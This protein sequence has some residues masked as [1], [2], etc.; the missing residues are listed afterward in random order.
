MDTIP[1]HI[2]LLFI[3]TSFLSF[4]LFYKATR[5]SKPTIIILVTWIILQTILGWSGFFQV[6]DMI[7]PRLLM[8]VLATLLL[9]IGLFSTPDGRNFIDALELKQLCLVH[10]VRIPVEIV[11]YLLFL[12]K[13]IPE[14]MTLSG[15]NYDIL[16]GITA[17]IIYY[18]G[19]QKK[20]LS[21]NIIL[22]W[23]FVCLGLLLNIVVNAVLAAPF[24]FQQFAFDQPNI[25]VL[26]FPFN[27]LPTLIV[28]IVLFSHLASI[29]QLMN[30]NSSHAASLR[31]G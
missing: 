25:A 19:F 31:K 23:N 5:Q 6:T 3:L 21:I 27:W 16:S 12:Q 13:A 9:I 11:L 28:P 1:F 7:P 18:F 17:P 30:K 22:I 14:L 26:H 29:R 10:L 24:P 20:I 8:F 15:R 4:I 2:N